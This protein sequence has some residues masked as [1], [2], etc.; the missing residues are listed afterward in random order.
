MI[1]DY[2]ISLIQ[3]AGQITSTQTLSE[4][5]RNTQ[6]TL[7]IM[8][9][10][11]S[12]ATGMQA[13]ATREEI[14]KAVNQKICD[15]ANS[16]RE[17]ISSSDIKNGQGLLVI[18]AI[19]RLTE[20]DPMN[21][22]SFSPY[23]IADFIKERGLWF[24]PSIKVENGAFSVGSGSLEPYIKEIDGVKQPTM[25]AEDKVLRGGR[26]R[27]SKLIMETLKSNVISP[28]RA[29]NLI[30]RLVGRDMQETYSVYFPRYLPP[31][32]LSTETATKMNRIMRSEERER[33]DEFLECW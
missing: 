20:C 23:E 33:E 1:L 9:R 16:R 22:K 5:L 11:F 2:L 6:E 8:S 25:Y 10:Y 28:T 18:Y 13:G 26:S 7:R 19:H 3:S 32:N 31:S 27:N 21:R 12:L 14:R 17:H 15:F 29:H 4:T 30:R 24:K